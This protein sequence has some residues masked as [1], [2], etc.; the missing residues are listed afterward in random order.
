MKASRALIVLAMMAGALV[1]LGHAQAGGV[2]KPTIVIERGDKCVDDPAVMRREH[3]NM[4]KHR[5][6]ETVHRGVRDPKYS[7]VGCIECH[8]SRKTPGVVG[9]V[10]GNDQNF[11]QSCHAYAAVKLDCFDCHASKPKALGAATSAASGAPP[12][13]A[14]PR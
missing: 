3:M 1:P 4:L 6:D 13:G 10:I 8:A 11:C 2:P 12:R 14:V 5:R 7:L 9:S